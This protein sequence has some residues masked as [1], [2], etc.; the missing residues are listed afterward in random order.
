MKKLYSLLAI[1]A[2]GFSANAQTNLVQNP[3]F[4]LG[5][6]PWAAGT[7]SGYSNP[8][9]VTTEKKSG[10]QSAGY[11]NATVTTG[12]YQNVPITSNEVYVLTYWYKSST[13]RPAGTTQNNI[14]RLWSVMTDANGKPTYTYASSTEDPLRTNN[15]YLPIASDWTQQTIEFTA[16]N[17]ATSIDVGF[18]AYGSG[19][20]YVDDVS[21]I[22]K[23]EL[24]TGET[25]LSKRSLVRMT[26]VSD[27]IEFVTKSDIKIVNVNGQVVKAA[28]VNDGTILNVSNLA[29]GMYIVTGNVNGE[30]VSQKIIKK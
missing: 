27:N 3:G 7:A 14:F 22:K 15:G 28:S 9:L 30:N 12:F 24:A 16:T 8:T 21:L 20:A 2:I 19:T 1:A 4:E 10:S 5:L 11:E 29:K 6:A 25:V 18:R 26:Q 13:S 23:S 17:V